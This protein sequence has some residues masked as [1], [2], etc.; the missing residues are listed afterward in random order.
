MGGS[1]EKPASQGSAIGALIA[2]VIGLCLCWP[3]GIIGIILGIIAVVN[4][5]SNPSTSRTCGLISWIAFGVGAV[6][7]I[8]YWVIY[9]FAAFAAY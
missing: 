2:N 5:T 9:G 6:A 4:V 1:G 7:G 3:F 8:A